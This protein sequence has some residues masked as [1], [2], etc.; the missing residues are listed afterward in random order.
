MNL[1][2]LA[3][4][5]L[6]TYAL[7]AIWAITSVQ[8]SS[9]TLTIAPKQTVTLQDLTPQQLEDRAEELLATT[10]STTITTSTITTQ[11]VT[12]LAPFNA[13]AKCQEWFPTAI[14]VGWP[15]DPQVL[16]TLGQIMWRESRCQPDACSKSDSGRQCRDYGLIQGNWYA[17][18]EWW[19]ELGIE[20]QDMFDPATNL[21]W[22][23]LLYSG[24]EAKGQCGWQPWR[25][26]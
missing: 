8:E 10:T 16:Q 7:M 14:S 21:G 5:A 3:I 22:A 23:Y 6:G 12:T 1:K 9:P 13:E 2:R 20:P 11:P 26:C 4:M 19:A 25:L 17:H 15:N 18:H 24:R